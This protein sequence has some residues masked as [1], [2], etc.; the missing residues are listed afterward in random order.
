MRARIPGS[1]SITNR[2]LLLAA[3]A[4]GTSR[5][6]LPLVSADTIAFRTALTSLG[7]R[8]RTWEDDE[9]WEVT[10]AGAR[11]RAGRPALCVREQLAGNAP[12]PFPCRPLP[13]VGHGAVRMLRRQRRSSRPGPWARSADTLSALGATV[14]TGTAGGGLHMTV[15][16]AGLDGGAVTVEF[17]GTE[18]HRTAAAGTGDRLEDMGPVRPRPRRALDRRPRRPPR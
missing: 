16:S 17:L 14:T 5:L 12:R 4:V 3:A 1:K 7:V 11:P 9:V 18:R 10:G 15:E 8:I 6:R 2:A 13:A